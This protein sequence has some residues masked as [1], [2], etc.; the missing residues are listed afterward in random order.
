MEESPVMFAFGVDIATSSQRVGFSCFY[1]LQ[2]PGGFPRA[3]AA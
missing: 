1:A 2:T 3:N